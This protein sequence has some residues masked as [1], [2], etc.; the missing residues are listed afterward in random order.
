MTARWNN[1]LLMTFGI[2]I[3]VYA[4]VALSTDWLTDFVGFIVMV[5]AGAVY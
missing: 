1:I 5:V 4:V 3:F 2:P